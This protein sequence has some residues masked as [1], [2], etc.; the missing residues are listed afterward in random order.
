MLTTE[1]LAVLFLSMLEVVAIADKR[2][3][4]R[5]NSLEVDGG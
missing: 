2:T 1:L 5:L 3:I 4:H